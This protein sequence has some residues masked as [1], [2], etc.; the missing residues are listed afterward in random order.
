MSTI[1][2]PVVNFARV[3]IRLRLCGC[4]LLCINFVFCN[5]FFNFELAFNIEIDSFIIGK[6]FGFLGLFVDT[7][8]SRFSLLDFS[9]AVL[10][11]SCG[12]AFAFLNPFSIKFCGY[13]KCAKVSCSSFIRMLRVFLLSTIV[14]S[15]LARLYGI[16]FSMF[17]VS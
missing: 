16:F 11:S 6:K 1:G 8:V 12:I 9:L 2:S 3:S 7:N 5:L 13:P 4:L 15:R 10:S 17:G 14:Q